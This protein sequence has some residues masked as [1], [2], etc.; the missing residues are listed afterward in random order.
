MLT[1]LEPPLAPQKNRTTDAFRLLV[2]N[3]PPVT[4][5]LVDDNE[6]LRTHLGKLLAHEGDIDCTRHFASPVT[7]LKTLAEQSGPDII[8]LDV[9][10]GEH[11]GLEAI[12]PIKNLSPNTRVIIFSTC[13]DTTWRYRAFYDGASDYLLKSYDLKRLAQRIRMAVNDNHQPLSPTKSVA[14]FKSQGLVQRTL[15]RLLTWKARSELA[16]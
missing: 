2:T 1:T 6:F 9:Q 12:R 13:Y 11:N 16:R 5:W 3:A 4:V 15:G 14:L 7:L 8:L 10:M